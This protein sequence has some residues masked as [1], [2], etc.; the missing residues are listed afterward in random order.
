MA[1]RGT[2]ASIGFRAKTG[3]AIVVALAAGTRWPDLILRR[4]ISLVDPRS[5][6]TRGPYHEVMELPWPDAVLAART[7]VSAIETVATRA[8]EALIAE[9]ASG[10]FRVRSV[11]IVGSPDSNVAKIGNPHIRAHAA[12]GMLFRHALE[13]A[14]TRTHIPSRTFSDRTISADSQRF[15]ARL[16]ILGKKAGAPWRTD[17]K[18][19]ATAAWLAMRA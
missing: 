12:E 18:N 1:R 13:V 15:A 10:S 8:L 3:R 17:E 6:A 14:A 5:R 19:A 16:A 4:E 2:D 9:L 11:G 7:S